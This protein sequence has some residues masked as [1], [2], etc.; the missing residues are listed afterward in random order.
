[1]CFFTKKTWKQ[2]YD[3]RIYTNDQCVYQ[4]EHIIIRKETNNTWNFR[5]LRELPCMYWWLSLQLEEQTCRYPIWTCMYTYTVIAQSLPLS[6]SHLFYLLSYF[7]TLS[8]FLNPSPKSLH[9]LSTM[10]M[11]CYIFCQNLL[12]YLITNTYN[13]MQ[14]IFAIV[15]QLWCMFPLRLSKFN[16]CMIK[17]L[18]C[19]N[20]NLIL[21][22][23]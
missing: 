2:L 7:I 6:I 12:N 9:S 18:N 14:D 10:L 17:S 16:P 22:F 8:Y 15:V 21:T 11:V 19:I 5:T 3:I 1:M 4:T 20:R 23:F 13:N